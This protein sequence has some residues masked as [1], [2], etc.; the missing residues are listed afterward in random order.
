M[1]PL[2]Q[3][4]SFTLVTTLQ[5]VFELNLSML[6]STNVTKYLQ[7]FGTIPRLKLILGLLL[8]VLISF[9]NFGIVL[10]CE[11]IWRATTFVGGRRHC[12]REDSRKIGM[13]G[14]QVE[15]GLVQ[16]DLKRFFLVNL[17]R[18]KTPSYTICSSFSTT[19]VQIDCGL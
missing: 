12:E 13:E 11:C 18:F 4:H 14:Q 16:Y 8:L 15:S 17:V 9:S 5:R 2:C 7:Y 10:E 1:G 3:T 6:S 19:N